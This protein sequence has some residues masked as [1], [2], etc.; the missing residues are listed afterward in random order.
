MLRTAKFLN[1][2]LDC[3]SDLID[4]ML[5]QRADL[6]KIHN[7]N[8]VVDSNIDRIKDSNVTIL[9]GGGSGHEPAHAGYIGTGMLVGAIL[10][11]IFASPTVNSI[12]TGIRICAGKQGLLV[13]VKNYTGDRLN[14]GI[15]VERAKAEGILVEMVVVDDD[16]ALPEGGLLP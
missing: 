10:G 7:V 2:N 5:L 8:V 6:R 12:L 15:A 11:N 9:C 4:S 16:V 1:D 3:V 13:I 14:F